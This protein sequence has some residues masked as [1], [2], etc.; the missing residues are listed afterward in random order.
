[1]LAAAAG[2]I[3]ASCSIPREPGHVPKK[4][5]PA[6]V[7]DSDTTASEAGLFLLRDSI[8]TTGYIADFIH[9]AAWMGHVISIIRTANTCP[10]YV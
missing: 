6:Q 4:L 2:T 9:Y 1:M 5:G 8:G 3:E 7:H 10:L